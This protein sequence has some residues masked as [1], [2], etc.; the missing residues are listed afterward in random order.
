MS[1]SRVAV[2]FETYSSSIIAKPTASSI[3]SHNLHISKFST[4]KKFRLIFHEMKKRSDRNLCQQG[5]FPYRIGELVINYKTGNRRGFFTQAVKDLINNKDIFTIPNIITTSRIVCSPFLG[6]AVACDMKLVALSG[7]I[8]FGFSDWL[9]G[10]LAKKLNQETVLGAFLDPAADKFMIGSLSVGLLYQELIP[11]P[12]VAIF[13]GRDVT[14]LVLSF[15]KRYSERPHGAP[16]FDTTHSATFSIAPSNLSKFNTVCQFVMIGSTLV[17]F[18]FGYPPL[19]YIEPLWWI[20][21]ATT[22]VSGLGYIDGSGL[23]SINRK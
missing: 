17:H 14:L 3:L 11:A 10:Y 16:F 2:C 23:K 12:L 4:L 5:V 21:G 22:V 8:L 1:K 6:I 7:C 19:S 9:D 15:L 20:S 13:I 18:S